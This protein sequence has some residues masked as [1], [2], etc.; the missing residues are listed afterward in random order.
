MHAN[1]L[2]GIA[3]QG[4]IEMEA[5]VA[6]GCQSLGETTTANTC[7]HNL[8]FELDNRPASQVSAELYH[9]LNETDK[10]RM[11]NVV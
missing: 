1:G 9:S 6:H 5:L 7:E 3:L 4:N 11:R 10:A 8:L 2:I